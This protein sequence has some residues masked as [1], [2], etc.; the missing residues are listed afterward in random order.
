ME[1]TGWVCHLNQRERLLH[2]LFV[3]LDF[4]G[5]VGISLPHI[6]FFFFF[7]LSTQRRADN[8]CEHT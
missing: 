3:A 1:V 5:L 8:S 7:P 6:D 2:T 4:G